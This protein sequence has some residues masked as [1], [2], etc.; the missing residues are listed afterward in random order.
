MVGLSSAAII[1]LV[2]GGK[3]FGKKL[4]MKFLCGKLLEKNSGK[5]LEKFWLKNFWQKIGDKIL[6]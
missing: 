2:L 3:N 1:L 5:E 6:M 4:A